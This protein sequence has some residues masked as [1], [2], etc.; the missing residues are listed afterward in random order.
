MHLAVDL[1]AH[2][3]MM[4]LLSCKQGPWTIGLLAKLSRHCL[5]GREKP[6]RVWQGAC[7]GLAGSSAAE[8]S[9]ASSDGSNPTLRESSIKPSC[10]TGMETAT[11]A[12]AAGGITTV[13]DMPLNNEPTTTT[14]FLVEK[15]IR[16]SWVRPVSP[17]IRAQTLF[18]Q[19]LL[20]KRDEPAA[21]HQLRVSL[22]VACHQA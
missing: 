15:K 4:P 9:P 13:I 19:S 16:A 21:E 1:A 8:A 3:R 18:L 6:L 11:K 7:R 12:A 10:G 17:L 5:A 22:H 14:S 20:Q 2:K